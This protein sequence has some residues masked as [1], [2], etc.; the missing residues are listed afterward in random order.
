MPTRA[1]TVADYL[2]M[3]PP[4]RRGPIKTVREVILAN[5]PPGFEE[6]MT[7]GLI[8]YVVPHTLY[9][10]GYHCDPK[11]A[12]AVCKSGLPEKSYGPLPD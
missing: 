12:S 10:A 7:Y 11:T 3:L 2:K 9:P 8:G 5:L 1:A 6:T 4:D